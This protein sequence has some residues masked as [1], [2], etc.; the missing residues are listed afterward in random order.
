MKKV[1]QQLNLK[2]HKPVFIKLIGGKF[3]LHTHPELSI[4]VEAEDTFDGNILPIID[5]R[6][7]SIEIGKQYIPGLLNS[8][9][10]IPIKIFVPDESTV[11][12]SLMAGQ[13]SIAGSYDHLRSS[14]TFGRI[15]IKVDDIALINSAD[16]E[17]SAGD[18]KITAEDKTLIKQRSGGSN[19]QLLQL[20]PAGKILAHTTLGDVKVE[21]PYRSY[22]F[23]A[24][25][26]MQ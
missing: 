10:E 13:I 24:T 1:Y 4:K 20:N 11:D 9:R 5:D 21:S 3:E 12:F 19:Y 16:L 2:R 8:S 25:E 18:V 17:V 23:K 7:N 22:N 6:G 15:Y 26:T 14:L